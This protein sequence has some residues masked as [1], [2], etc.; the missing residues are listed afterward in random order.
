MPHAIS[1]DELD[2]LLAYWDAANYLT[3]AQ[4]YLQTTRALRKPL[5]HIKPRLLGHWGTSPGLSL[6]Y[7]QLNRLILRTNAEVLY[8]TG[9]GAHRHDDLHER[10]RRSHQ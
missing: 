6:V 4:I 1:N 3:V 7:V 9:P 8:V 2:R 10:Q 5:Q